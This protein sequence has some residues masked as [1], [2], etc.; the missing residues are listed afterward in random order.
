MRV[1]LGA[2]LGVLGEALV[3]CAPTLT[4]REPRMGVV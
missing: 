1:I 4:G 3:A 2:V